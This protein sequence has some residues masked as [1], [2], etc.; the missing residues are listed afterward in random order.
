SP[1]DPQSSSGLE[2]RAEAVSDFGGIPENFPARW[3]LNDEKATELERFYREDLADGVRWFKMPTLLPQGLKNRTV[4]FQ[5][6]YTRKQL[7]G[8]EPLWE[9]TANMQL[10]LRE[11]VETLTSRPYR[12]EF[13]DTAHATFNTNVVLR[14]PPTGL[15]AAGLEGMTFKAKLIKKVSYSDYH[16]PLS[17][18]AG[19]S[20][21]TFKARL[22]KK[23]EY[24][25]YTQPLSEAAGLDEITFKAR[26]IKRV[27]EA[28]PHYDGVGGIFAT[29]VT[30]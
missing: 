27:I 21:M 10:Y 30:L 23:V 11:S 7:R 25:E 15:S 22:I 2:G 28:E 3:I 8:G 20:S 14:S 4:K 16:Q 13:Y 24:G 5:G 19:L 1:V 17:E 26:L 9:Y 6:A 29:E 12:L 18:A